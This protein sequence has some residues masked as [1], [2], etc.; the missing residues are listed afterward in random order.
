VEL[1]VDRIANRDF[2]FPASPRIEMVESV[3]VNGASLRR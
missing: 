2:G 1:L 3:W